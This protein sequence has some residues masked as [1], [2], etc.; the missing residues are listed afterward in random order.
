LTERVIRTLEDYKTNI[1][2][3]EAELAEIEF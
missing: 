3:L 2:F 1:C